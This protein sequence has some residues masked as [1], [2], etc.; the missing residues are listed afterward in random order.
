MKKACVV[1]M[2]QKLVA[3]TVVSTSRRAW[4]CTSAIG[5]L[6]MTGLYLSNQLTFFIGSMYL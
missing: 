2:K 5:L 4:R 1:L 3:K 6:M